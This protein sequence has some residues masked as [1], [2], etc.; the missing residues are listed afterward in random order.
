MH[1]SVLLQE[2]IK[3]LEVKKD[4][5]FVDATLGNGG[6][7]KEILKNSSPKILIGIDADQT[8]INFAKENLK[9]FNQVQKFYSTTY[10]DHIDKVLEN[11][12]ISKVDKILFD[13]GIRTDQIFDSN[14]GFSFL[15]EGP[16]K[17]TFSVLPEKGQLTA[18]EIVN[19][20]SE[21]SL[22]DIIYGFGEEKFARRIAKKIV[23]FRQ[24]ETITTTSQLAKIISEATPFWYQKQK[25]HPA[26]KTFQAIR[27]AVNS[28][29]SR[30]E[31]ALN[32]SWGLLNEN[33]R[34]AVITFHSIEDRL[35]KRL[36][37]KFVEN[38]DGK[39]V[40]KKVI[41]PEREEIIKNPKS[42]SAKLR[43]IEKK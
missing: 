38:K 43:V 24:K 23:D 39:L 19:D 40:N 3:N 35:V 16:L 7:S 36:F 6:H 17:M 42:R 5:I 29:L 13:L 9:E 12:H 41:I 33:G 21:E 2:V 22:A 4:E 15:E 20:W 18:E 10:F 14:R 8:A 34:I 28:E 11:H 30:I 1:K 37:K 31:N 26:T 25:I 27:M 32:K